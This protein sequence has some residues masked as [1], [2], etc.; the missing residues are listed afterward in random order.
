MF[1]YQTAICELTGLPVSNASVYEG[2]SRGRRRRVSG[3]APQ[4]PHA[5]SS[6]ARACTR[7]RSR[8]CARSRTATGWSVVEVPLARRRHRSRRRGPRRS[9]GT[10]A[11]RSSPS[12]TSTAPS[13]TPPRSAPPPSAP[14]AS[15]GRARPS[16][17]AQV[18]PITL[19]RARR[20]RGVRRGRRR[21]RGPAARQ[22][23]R[24]RR[25]VVRFLRRARGVPAPD[26]R[27]DR[28]RDRGR[29]R[30]PRLRAD[31][32]DARA[33]HPPRESDLEHLHLAGAQRAR[34][35]RL[36]GVAR[37]AA[38]SSSWASCCSRAPTTRARRSP[39]SRA[40]RSCTSSRSSASSRAPRRRRRRPRSSR[41]CARAGV[42]PGVDV[43][44]LSGREEDRGGAARGDHRAALARGHRPARRRARRGRR[45]RARDARDV[46]RWTLQ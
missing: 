33:A 13:R 26:A 12:P 34:R 46:K 8:R 7:T 10:R 3:E 35:R 6:S 14:P 17:I 25:A 31:A 16:S 1:E 19:G 5:A 27:A 39:R 2:P 28:R 32:A 9:T 38:G 45:R 41:R 42:N 21:R 18:D 24:L 30:A 36:P 44:A 43:H 4:R 11:P 37:A 20:A 15:R 29:G 40:W 23:P 22:P